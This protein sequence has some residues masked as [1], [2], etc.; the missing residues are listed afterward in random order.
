MVK[1]SGG[2]FW[3]GAVGRDEVKGVIL[4]HPQTKLVSWETLQIIKD[5]SEKMI[6]LKLKK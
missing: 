5:F 4:F 6:T 2:R 3:V 1:L